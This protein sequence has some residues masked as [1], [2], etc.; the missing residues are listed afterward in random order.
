[1][2]TAIPTECFLAREAIFLVQEVEWQEG[3]AED[4]GV[5]L[6]HFGTTA[7]DSKDKLVAA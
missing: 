1:M 3:P 2:T 5:I 4:S 6:Q 7:L